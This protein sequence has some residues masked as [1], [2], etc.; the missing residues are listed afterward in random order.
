MLPFRVRLGGRMEEIHEHVA[1]R[2][3]ARLRA[4]P[5]VCRLLPRRLQGQIA[6]PLGQGFAVALGRSLDLPQLLGRNPR[7]DGFGSEGRLLLDACGGISGR[8]SACA[9]S[10]QW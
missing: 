10:A 9:G 8:R 1:G 6:Q 7:G 3:F 4:V 2:R 5:W